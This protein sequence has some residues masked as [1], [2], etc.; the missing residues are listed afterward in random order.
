M[1]TNK[2]SLRHQRIVSF[3]DS[4][5]EARTLTQI[6]QHLN[7]RANTQVSRKTVERDIL[8]LT[9]QYQIVESPGRP[10]GFKIRE[11]GPREYHLELGEADLQSLTVAISLLR[12][13]SPEIF[14]ELTDILEAKILHKLPGLQK[15]EMERF[16]KLCIARGDP[17]GKT[18][19]VERE[20]IL[21]LLKALRKGRAVQF[22]YQSPYSDRG[23]ARERN[24][25]LILL[26]VFG[27]SFFLL[28][29]DLD[30]PE[31]E[32]RTKRLALP[33]IR[34]V[35]VTEIDYKAPPASELK[36]WNN[37]YAGLGG[38]QEDLRQIKMQVGHSFGNYLTEHQVH[39]SQ[40]MT[41]TKGGYRVEFTLP[42]GAPFLR[43]LAGFAWDIKKVEPKAVKSELKE[44]LRNGLKWI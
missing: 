4:V 39:P 21:L 42:M 29:E 14:S 5:R 23:P 17:M 43:F 28:A 38:D 13:Q 37:S 34:K 41:K 24:F 26:E 20:D 8:D 40:K 16:A 25:G 9:E 36:K 1:S 10:V 27:G 33:R 44:M 3:L 31:G 6:C 22:I 12:Y 18:S 30:I 2:R 11:G 35:H 7:S 19:G 15:M 32:P